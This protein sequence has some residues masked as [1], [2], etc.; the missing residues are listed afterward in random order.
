MNNKLIRVLIE[1]N[2]SDTRIGA[3]NDA[4]DLVYFLH[5]KKVQFLFCGDLDS[6]I[7]KKLKTEGVKTIKGKSRN[8][9][10]LSMLLYLFNVI[11]WI[12]KLLVYRPNVVHMNF[13]GYG[14]SLAFA[15]RILGI[16]IVA[17]AGDYAANNLANRWIMAY[18]ANGSA[19]AQHLL[20]SPLSEKVFIVGDLFRPERLEKMIESGPGLPKNS[21]K[22]CFLYLGQLVERKGIHVLVEAFSQIQNDAELYIIGGNWDE[23]GYPRRLLKKIHNLRLNDN[24]FTYSHRNDIGL[25][26]KQCDVFV[27]PSL[28]EARPRSIIEAMCMSRPVISTTV[29]G[30]PSLVEDGTTGLLVPPSNVKELS[31]AI[32]QM[33]S[34]R[35]LR[36]KFG[37]AA[38]KRANKIFQPDKTADRYFDLYNSL[39]QKSSNY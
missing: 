23:T 20:S 18:V 6:L 31:K 19:Q 12:L 15:S 37:N 39:V 10:K 38:L 22:P 21:D 8:I 7:R 9:S 1:L 26:L 16:P 30:I 33:A 32:D 11:G 3:V 4:L 28:S 14:S 17:R 25:L 27:L 24:V 34:S 13:M 36:K 5:S 2:S 29:G 35:E